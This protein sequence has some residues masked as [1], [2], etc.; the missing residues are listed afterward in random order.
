MVNIQGYKNLTG[1]LIKYHRER[2]DVSQKELCHGICVVSHLSKIENNKVEAS[3]EIIDELFKKLGIDYYQDEGFLNENKLKIKNFFHN[4]NYYRDSQKI[5]NEINDV[6]EKLINSPLIIDYLLVESYFHIKATS[7]IKW[8][9]ELE[10]YMDSEQLGWF[11]ILKA[12]PYGINETD[13]RELI[14]RAISLLRNSYASLS[15]MYFELSYGN[16]DK[17][18]HL[19]PEVTNI[20]LNEGNITALAHMNVCVGNC[21]SAQ[22]LPDLMLAHYER[23]KNILTD[24]NN[25]ELISTLNYNIGATYLESDRFEESLYYL[26]MAKGNIIK[27]KDDTNIFL[28]YHKLSLLYLKMKNKKKAKNYINKAK[29]Y[30]KVTDDNYKINS[31]MIEVAELQLDEDYLDNPIYLDKL[32]VLCLTLKKEYPRGFYLFHKRMLEQL[33]CH[34]RQYK[35]AYLLK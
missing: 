9:R 25:E 16:Y 26:E 15:L 5:F 21:Y 19:S 27:F 2:L 29:D 23:A 7:N 35:K 10:I 30:I 22:N 18:I 13:Q 11:Y 28:L 6:K 31:L 33:Y 8:L 1:S 24:I 14:S 20:A 3:P 17:V 4:L 12:A 34:L 32:E